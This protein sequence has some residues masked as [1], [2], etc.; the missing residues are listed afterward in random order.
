MTYDYTQ[1]QTPIFP[2]INDSPQS[3]TSTQASNGSDLIDKVNTV[4]TNL[5]TDFAT[6]NSQLS[7]G[8][9]AAPTTIYVDATNGDD[10]NDGETS[11]TAKATIQAAID[12][13]VGKDIVGTE[14]TQVDSTQIV[15]TSELNFLG[16]EQ[17]INS[18]NWT[19]G[20]G[21]TNF[22]DF[23]KT[24]LKLSNFNLQ[25]N[26]SSIGLPI[27]LTKPRTVIV[28]E[29]CTI[30]V[31]QSS[32]VTPDCF[33][34]FFSC[35]FNIEVSEMFETPLT[36]DQFFKTTFYFEFCSFY[37]TNNLNICQAVLT[38][39][40]HTE[41]WYMDC[42]FYF[43]V[44]LFFIN[45]FNELYKRKTIIFDS[46][47]DFATSEIK[48][49]NFNEASLFNRKTTVEYFQLDG[50]LTSIISKEN[51]FP[52]RLVNLHIPDTNPIVKATLITQDPSNQGFFNTPLNANVGYICYFI[53]F[54]SV[55]AVPDLSAGNWVGKDFSQGGNLT[56]S[57]NS[58]TTE[59]EYIARSD[60]VNNRYDIGFMFE[61]NGA[62]IY[63]FCPLNEDDN[64]LPPQ[65]IS[66]SAIRIKEIGSDYDVYERN[67]IQII[68]LSEPFIPGEKPL[69]SGFPNSTGIVFN[70]KVENTDDIIVDNKINALMYQPK[71]DPFINFRF[72]LLSGI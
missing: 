32:T 64:Y 16:I 27:I 10:N 30:D 25:F 24:W 58:F 4:L 20:A 17:P 41:E 5:N 36:I 13:L 63:F 26:L 6:I 44:E 23:S 29:D 65:G 43:F 8:S 46:S 35:T 7:G 2:G 50:A 54:G 3:A 71:G 57:K 34:Y 61:N 22:T 66:G 19:L 68:S 40:G 51:L 60:F 9:V 18:N 56:H 49:L 21:N 37:N 70:Y 69:F 59:C 48:F 52:N 47:S 14:I 62:G 31:S 67:I 42:T 33:Y 39:Q 11:N 55:L 53:P 72:E 1:E 45:V 12:S 38:S 15:L 28:F